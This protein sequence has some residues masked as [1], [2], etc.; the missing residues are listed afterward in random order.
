MCKKSLNLI[1]LQCKICYLI[2]VEIVHFIKK[3]NLEYFFINSII[4]KE[5]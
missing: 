2:S 4:V 3:R 5:F 1:Y